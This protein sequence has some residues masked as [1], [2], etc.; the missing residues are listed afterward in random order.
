MNGY[1]RDWSSE[2][3]GD[4]GVEDVLLLLLLSFDHAVS[5]LIGLHNL[6]YL[7][8]CFRFWQTYA[9]KAEESTRVWLFFIEH[10]NVSAVITPKLLPR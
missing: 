1:N 7:L 2:E 10:S 5:V 9:P 8:R 6:D 4:C 3:L